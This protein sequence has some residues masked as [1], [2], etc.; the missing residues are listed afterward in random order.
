MRT[1]S[2]AR[3]RR[4]SSP[5]FDPTA[6]QADGRF[7]RGNGVGAAGTCFK[8][9]PGF[10]AKYEPIGGTSAETG[11]PST[12]TRRERVAMQDRMTVGG[13]GQRLAQL[14]RYPQTDEKFRVIAKRE[15][16][17][18]LKLPVKRT[19]AVAAALAVDLANMQDAYQRT[20]SNEIERADELRRQNDRLRQKLA[21][22]G[23]AIGLLAS[24]KGELSF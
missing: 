13:C 16:N 24:I 7:Y 8:G 14:G 15:L 3:V 20:R 23:D 5:S 18:A 10:V 4:K 2:Q 9:E 6:K 11:G 12:L 1:K 17:A 19:R 21:T 22:I